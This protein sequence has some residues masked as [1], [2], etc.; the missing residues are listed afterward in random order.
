MNTYTDEEIRRQIIKRKRARKR[1]RMNILRLIIIALALLI[2]IYAGIFIGNKRYERDIA[3]YSVDGDNP[4]IVQVAVSQADVKNKGGKKFWSWYGYDSHVS[5]C[6][7]FVSWCGNETGLIKQGKMPKYAACGDGTSWFKEHNKWLKGGETPKSG[8]IIFF[9]WE[10][11]PGY[12]DHTGIVTGVV[13]EYVFTV[14]GNSSN[15]CRRKRY[16]IDNPVILG[17]GIIE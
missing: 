16:R 2:A 11:K 9:N 4:E 14:E 17:Y 12:I 3:T 10:Q 13:G 7:T 6:A 1:R 5:W 8:D 15:R